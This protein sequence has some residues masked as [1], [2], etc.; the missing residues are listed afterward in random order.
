MKYMTL[1]IG[2]LILLPNVLAAITVSPISW[3][4]AYNKGDIMPSKVFTFSNTG[5]DNISISLSTQLGYANYTVSSFTVPALNSRDITV[6]LNLPTNIQAN[7]YIEYVKYTYSSTTESIPVIITVESDDADCKLIPLITNFITTIQSNTD[8]YSKRFSVAVSNKCEEH[9]D[10]KTP[11][12]IGITETS[13]GSKPIGLTG[14]LSLG[15]KEPGQEAVFD[16]QFDV[17]GLQAGIYS[18]SIIIPGT[19]QGEKIQ[20]TIDFVITVTGSLSPITSQINPPIYEIPSQVKRGDSFEIKAISLNSN[21]Q[22]QLFYNPKLVGTK[23]DRKEESWTW[24]GY[25]NETGTVEVSITS[26]YAG[27][28]I[29]GVTTR[30][31]IVVENYGDVALAGNIT[32]DLYPKEE[33]LKDGD[34]VSVLVRSGGNIINDAILYING[35]RNDEKQ[36]IIIGGNTYQL[37]ATHPNFATIDKVIQLPKRELN[38]ILNPYDPEEGEIG[39]LMVTDLIFGGE[40]P[41]LIR[42]DNIEVIQGQNFS[43]GPVGNHILDASANGFAPYT[44]QI[45]VT[46]PTTLKSAPEKLKKDKVNSLNLS[47]TA[48]WK[49]TWNNQDKNKPEIKMIASGTGSEIK[50]T[51]EKNGLYQIL[52]RNN[53]MREYKLS[54]FSWSWSWLWIPIGIIMVIIVILIIGALSSGGGGQKS[55][56]NRVGYGIPSMP[57]MPVSK[58]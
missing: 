50:F 26:M 54:G 35:I 53:L 16:V 14:A 2:L 15:Q 40:V 44:R 22:P 47:K 17:K 18:P 45:T 58:L 42:Y 19:Y 48:F 28:Q 9:V 31:I 43:F 34:N 56:G 30:K 51:P 49:V 46:E 12:I 1:L 57:N 27:G 4:V 38:V 20:T 37:S 55:S 23:V 3:T 21:L 10:I 32:F 36:F 11:M 7:T 8:V 52:V 6:Y 39:T 41:A 25:I 24:T 33:L 5:T 29:G 13:S